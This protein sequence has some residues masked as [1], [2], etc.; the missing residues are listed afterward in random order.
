MGFVSPIFGTSFI[1][2]LGKSELG[3]VGVAAATGGIEVG[4]IMGARSISPGRPTPKEC[5][6]PTVPPT[7]LGATRP[8]PDADEV[9]SGAPRK[10]GSRWRLRMSPPPREEAA[11]GSGANVTA[12]PPPELWMGGRP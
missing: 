1:I 4:P 12:V 9:G 7:K 5:G 6:A 11:L 3:P 2:G 10:R 8:P